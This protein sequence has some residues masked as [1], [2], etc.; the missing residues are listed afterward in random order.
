VTVE[1]VPRARERLLGRWLHASAPRVVAGSVLTEV[2]DEIE[3]AKQAVVGLV[4]AH[5]QLAAEQAVAAVER[6]VGEIKL[7]REHRLA[8]RLHLHVDVPGAAVVAAPPDRAQ[9]EAA[10]L[11]GEQMPAPNETAR[12]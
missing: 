2:E 9:G 12:F 8:G 10:G 3:P 7:G 6:L 5:D 1:L 11:I 4:E